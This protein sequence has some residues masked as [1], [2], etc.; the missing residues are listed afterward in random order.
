MLISQLQIVSGYSTQVLNGGKNNSNNVR[1]VA[2]QNVQT[3]LLQRS[4]CPEVLNP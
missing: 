1:L 4:R 3:K 2:F